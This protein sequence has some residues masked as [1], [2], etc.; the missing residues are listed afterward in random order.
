MM[1]TRS[2]KPGDIVLSNKGGRPFYAKVIGG[3]AGATLN[4]EPLERGVRH[5]QVKA[6]EIADHWAHAV[7]TRREDRAP[8]AQTTLDLQP[9]A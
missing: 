9:P 3:G 7:A 5:R 8:Q 2:I 6:S 1:R 4:V